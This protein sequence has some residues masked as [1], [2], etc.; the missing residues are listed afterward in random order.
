MDNIDKLQMAFSDLEPSFIGEG[1]FDPP[2]SPGFPPDEDDLES[3]SPSP[4][5]D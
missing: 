5:W 4:F 2:A 3:S 1:K